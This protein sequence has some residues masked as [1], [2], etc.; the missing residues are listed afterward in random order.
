MLNSMLYDLKQIQTITLSINGK[1]SL[2]KIRD[3]LQIYYAIS[4]E[5]P[6]FNFLRVRALCK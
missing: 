2:V 5:L 4:C 1:D 6:C 3:E